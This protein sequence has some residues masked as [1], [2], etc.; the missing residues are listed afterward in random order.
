MRKHESGE[1]VS[2]YLQSKGIPGIKY[3]DQGSRPMKGFGRG[4][5]LSLYNKQPKGQTWL[6]TADTGAVKEFKDYGEAEKWMT[7]Q[8]QKK[9]SNFVLFDD[10]I[11]QILAINDDP[12]AQSLMR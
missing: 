9:T 10:Q 3:L 6:A 11:P 8:V 7:E 2:N 12:I 4:Q 1:D 5:I